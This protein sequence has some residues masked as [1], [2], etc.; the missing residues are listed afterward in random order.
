MN[1]DNNIK[2]VLILCVLCVFAVNIRGGAEQAPVVKVIPQP[3]QIVPRDGVC[4]ISPE[5]SIVV[6]GT[7]TDSDILAAELISQ[8]LESLWGVKVPV[9][10]SDTAIR[11]RANLII[12]GLPKRDKEIKERAA[13]RGLI[14]NPALHPQGYLMS[15]EPD[16]IF[17]L[18]NEPVGAFYAAQTLRQ[19]IAKPQTEV[20]APCLTITDW[21][22]YNYRGF[23][24]DITHNPM[25]TPEHFKSIIRTM[26]LYKLNLLTFSVEFVLDII[27]PDELKELSKEAKRY[28]I[29]LIGGIQSGIALKTFDGAIVKPG[30]AKYYDY[31]GWLYGQTAPLFES[32]FFD[33][34]CSEASLEDGKGAG[35]NASLDFW[36]HIQKL[37]PL[38]ARQYKRPVCRG[39]MFLKYQGLLTQLPDKAVIMNF[40]DG[41]E[42]ESRLFRDGQSD[43]QADYRPLVESVLKAKLSQFL[44]PSGWAEGTIYPDYRAVNNILKFSRAGLPFVEAGKPAGSPFGNT[45]DKPADRGKPVLGL[46]LA[47]GHR[48]PGPE[49]FE[50]NWFNILWT[51]ECGWI[52][53]RADTGLFMGKFASA[54]FGVDSADEI[55][56]TAM[57]LT[58]PNRI[59]GYQ[60]DII[61]RFY[62]NPFTTDFH[63][64]VPEFYGCLKEIDKL[65]GDALKLLEELS[66]K[67]KRQKETIDAWGH[68][69]NQWQ[70]LAYKFR[71]S[72]N[73]VQRYH[74]LY[75]TDPN[76]PGEI[77][78]KATI[79]GYIDTLNAL[80]DKTTALQSE[81]NTFAGK[82]YH[83]QHLEDRYI[84][85]AKLFGDKA[86]QLKDIQD[87]SGRTGRLTKPEELGLMLKSFPERVISPDI[88]SAG[89]EVA[90]RVTW[91]NKDWAFRV[92]IR[93]ENKLA[94]EP[95][96][97]NKFACPVEVN[98]NLSQLIVEA[99]PD[100]KG[101]PVGVTSP[102]PPDADIDLNSIRVVEYNETGVPIAEHPCQADKQP[103]F[104][105]RSNADVNIFWALRDKADA[106]GAR[107]FYI[108]F[109]TMA[110]NP[111]PEPE[112]KLSLIKQSGENGVK[113]DRIKAYLAPTKGVINSWKVRDISSGLFS[114]LDILDKVSS[115]IL[116]SVDIDKDLRYT[117][118]TEAQGPLMV[119][120]RLVSDGGFYKRF[121][122]YEDLPIVEVFT[123]S[124]LKACFNSAPGINIT[125]RQTLQYLF[126]NYQNGQLKSGAVTPQNVF[127]EVF[128]S[129]LRRN[130]GLTLGLITPDSRVGHS[131]NYYE[132]RLSISAWRTPAGQAP[133][134]FIIYA[135]KLSEDTFNTFNCLR[136]IF[137]LTDPDKGRTLL[138]QRGKCEYSE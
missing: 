129:S 88:I 63:L 119:R 85:L 36:S 22:I 137:N 128:W 56:R 4:V 72:H 95:L 29:E 82:Q 93:L 117:L 97:A 116:T 44:C 28:H 108:Y 96:G 133:A 50:A 19:I 126:S 104:N 79:D 13:G 53:D 68:L 73:L 112:Y 5:W 55:T 120:Y 123:N 60:P 33:I 86:V 16:M 78:Y 2:L 127:Q 118:E 66:K 18:A 109:D 52:P 92:A 26:A 54:F 46:V 27:T 32:P 105:P 125:G 107:Y 70:Y 91:W 77:N 87:V 24:M 94:R 6:A 1:T 111:K 8:D 84:A 23:Q 3:R 100:I 39:D 31:L 64:Q 81:R 61:D 115:F 136:A 10:A 110:H 30:Q 34:G 102:K 113:N 134:H 48:K 15:I 51:A 35:E 98:L 57:L 69:A 106:N 45:Q 80:R 124:G 59:L 89:P 75:Y 99:L 40:A 47:L 83:Y 103:Y 131:I 58:E 41:A 43:G 25:P 9:Q 114:S 12:I 74:Q 14:V 42:A 101:L 71:E 20:I 7:A 38:T 76:N 67:V 90:K 130:D 37:L 49:L 138:L 121:T 17:L 65:S 11:N 132:Q 21:P 62:E 135:D 122:F